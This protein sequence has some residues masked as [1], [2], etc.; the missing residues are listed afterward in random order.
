MVSELGGGGQKTVEFLDRAVSGMLNV[1]RAV[2]ILEGAVTQQEDQQ[3][4]LKTLTTLRPTK[5][6]IL[7]SNYTPDELHLEV[8]RGT[9]LGRVVNAHNF[10]IEEELIAPFEPTI[11]V[12]TREEFTRI[13]PGR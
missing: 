12:L 5:G 6:G 9:V 4:V 10:E 7:L 11:I 1:L 13:E 3:K 2:G 8:P